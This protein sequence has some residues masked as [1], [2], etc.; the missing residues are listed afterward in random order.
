PMMTLD[1]YLGEMKGISLLA[2]SVDRLLVLLF[3]LKYYVGR[4]MF[5]KC[6]IIVWIVVGVSIPVAFNVLLL[7][8]NQK[9]VSILCRA[10]E[11]LQ[12]PQYSL[13]VVLRCLFGLLSIIVMLLVILLLRKI[14]KRRHASGS[15]MKDV[16]IRAFQDKQIEFTKTML[17]SCAVTFVLFVIPDFAS[18]L[19]QFG[20]YGY[21]K[22]AA[23][24]SRYLR[25]IN[26]FNVVIVTIKCQNDV[27]EELK[28]ILTAVLRRRSNV[29]ALRGEK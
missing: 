25:T 11:V 18:A 24:L 4:E 7:Y 8:S 16:Q 9:N 20:D 1:V 3:P 17:I 23:Q 2:I 13:F 10:C 5:T 15:F 22:I 6:Q 21:C 29:G 28:V 27:R 19:I 26:C 12:A 14:S